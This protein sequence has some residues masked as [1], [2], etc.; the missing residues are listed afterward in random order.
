MHEQEWNELQSCVDC[1]ANI[2]P[3]SDRAYVLS[4]ELCLCFACAVR[5]G[6][7]YDALHET[8]SV[9]PDVSGEPDE[10]RDPEQLD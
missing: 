3:G 4:E 8:W 5:R 6:G 10:R 1:G 7:K 2:E 9:A